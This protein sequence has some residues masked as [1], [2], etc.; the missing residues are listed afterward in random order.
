MDRYDEAEDPSFRNIVDHRFSLDLSVLYMSLAEHREK[1]QR[2]GDQAL[3]SSYLKLLME[4]SVTYHDLDAVRP[5]IRKDV[6]DFLR[7]EIDQLKFVLR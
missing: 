7:V 2:Q 1:S 5:T 4:Q 3:Y 6:F